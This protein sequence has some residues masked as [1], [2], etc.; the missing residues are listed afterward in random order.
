MTDLSK[1]PGTLWEPDNTQDNIRCRNCG[2]DASG[3]GATEI[4]ARKLGF[5]SNRKDR[6]CLP[7][8]MTS[9]DDLFAPK[10]LGSVRWGQELIPTLPSS[11]R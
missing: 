7:S 2:R 9:A 6:V 1:Y 11:R 5:P 4:V 3:H 8:H 10:S